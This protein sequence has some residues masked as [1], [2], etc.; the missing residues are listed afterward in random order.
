MEMNLGADKISKLFMKY[1]IP[2]AAA[3]VVTALYIIVDGMFVGKGVGSDGVAA[4]GIVVPVFTIFQSVQFLLGV[5]GS[6]VASIA[7]AKNDKKHANNVF[8]QSTLIVVI[9]MSIVTIISLIFTEEIAI[10]MGANEEILPNVKTYFRTMVS[11][12]IFTT[13]NPTWSFFVRLDGSPKYS[14]VSMI[15]G[16]ITNVILDYVFIFPM[17]MGIFGAALAT[18]IG[19][20]TSILIFIYYFTKKSKSFSFTKFSLNLKDIKRVLNIGIPGFITNIFTAITMISFNVVIMHRLGKDGVTTY[21][22][23]NYL[24]P[25]IVFLFMSIGQSIQPIASFNYGIKNKERMKEVYIFGQKVAVVMGVFFTLIGILGSKSLVGLFIDKSSTAYSLAV[26]SIPLFYLN[27]IFYGINSVTVSYYQ[28]IEE[29]KKANFITLG[30]GFLF[31]IVGIIILPNIFGNTGI[32]L[33]T[34]FAEILGLGMVGYYIFKDFIAGT[35]E[36]KFKLV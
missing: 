2:T 5:G 10:L 21:G 3:M 32:W 24:H 7:L 1:F 15:C 8:L 4:V 26:T 19:H 29:A 31:I 20:I 18:G 22:V 33:T 13:L 12:A 23:I 6:T 25:L 11:Y 34:P 16:A 36:E 30:R 35:G 14:M 9:I 17:Q 28:S 27:Y